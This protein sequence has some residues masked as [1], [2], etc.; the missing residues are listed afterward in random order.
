MRWKILWYRLSL[1][2]RHHAHKPLAESLKHTAHKIVN[3]QGLRSPHLIGWNIQDYREKSVTIFNIPTG[4]KDTMMPNPSW[5]EKDVMFTTVTMSTYDQL[6]A[7]FS[8]VCEIC[9]VHSIDSV[10]WV[11]H[12]GLL[13]WERFD[14]AQTKHDWL[15]YL[16]VIW[17]LGGPWPFKAAKVPSPPAV[18]LKV[19]LRETSFD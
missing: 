17:P 5:K 10:K 13:F 9:K 1:C 11:L 8:K 12:T 7:G 6:N 18:S 2:L 19:W 16:S 4:N 14:V 3:T 15:L